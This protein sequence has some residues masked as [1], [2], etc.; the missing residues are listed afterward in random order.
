MPPK[1]VSR[2]YYNGN[3]VNRGLRQAG[4]RLLITWESPDKAS[5]VSDA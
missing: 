2:G 1:S 3:K 5:S 4:E